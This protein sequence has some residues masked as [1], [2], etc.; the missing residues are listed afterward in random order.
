MDENPYQAPQTT[1]ALPAQQAT[2]LHRPVSVQAATVVVVLWT[3][4][5]AALLL[6]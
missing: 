1:N 6:G 5:A 4:L 2:W 3:L